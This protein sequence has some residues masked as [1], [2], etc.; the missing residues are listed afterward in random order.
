MSAGPNFCLLTIK[1]ETV[2][3]TECRPVQRKPTPN[4]NLTLF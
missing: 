3:L 4:R 1:D 2:E